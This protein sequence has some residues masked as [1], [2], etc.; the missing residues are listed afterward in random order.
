MRHPLF[1]GFV[2]GVGA[3]WAYHHFAP[4]KGLG[5]PGSITG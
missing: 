1:W 2:L 4:G 5:Q 3:T